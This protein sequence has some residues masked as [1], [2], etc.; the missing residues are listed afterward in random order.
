MP[1]AWGPLTD[2][3]L[4]AR[5]IVGINAETVTHTSAND[6]PGHYGPQQ[7]D[8]W[9]LDRFTQ[10]LKV[11]FHQNEPYDAVFSLVG[12]DASIANAFRRILVAEVPTL[13]IEDVFVFNNTS[14]IQDEV[15]AHRLG[16]IPLTG[17]EEGL[18]WM[19]WFR[20][21]PP[22]DDYAAQATFE[23]EGHDPSESVPSDYNTV[24]M[25][26]DVECRWA[27]TELD[28]RDGKALAKA[29]STDPEER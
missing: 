8:T 13:A 21:P 5:R 3:Q 29:G 11:D 19:R 26:L 14:I 7:D 2:E 18:Q 22:K 16:L 27:T 25:T 15:L 4:E 10:Q 12:V 24:V 20:K 23:E 1:T 9:D 28:G 6:I 17:G